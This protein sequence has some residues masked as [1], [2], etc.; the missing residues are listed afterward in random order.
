MSS[1]AYLTNFMEQGPCSHANS[2]SSRQEIPHI[3][4]SQHTAT[5]PYPEPDESTPHPHPI[6]LRF[7]LILPFH[8]CLGLPH[9]LIPSGCQT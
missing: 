5:V 8:L 6:S 2:H 1:P 4:Y 9:G 3:L 7:I